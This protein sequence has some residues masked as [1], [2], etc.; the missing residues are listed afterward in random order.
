MYSRLREQS[1]RSDLVT[2]FKRFVIL[3]GRSRSAGTSLTLVLVLILHESGEG[4]GM[5]G[6]HLLDFRLFG[7][8]LCLAVG[9]AADAA[10]RKAAG[11]LHGLGTEV[12]FWVVLG[13]P[14]KPKDHAL[15][16]KA[17]DCEQ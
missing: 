3:H 6:V 15:H 10:P 5:T 17:S 1:S 12:D 16:A 13:E 2:L 14:A 8:Q 9:F 4:S 11:H 7:G